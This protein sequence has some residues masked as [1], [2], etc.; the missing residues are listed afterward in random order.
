[1]FRAFVVEVAGSAPGA[2]VVVWLRSCCGL[3]GGGC[4]GVGSLGSVYYIVV[5]VGLA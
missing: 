5:S 3:G 4:C 2:G 1:M